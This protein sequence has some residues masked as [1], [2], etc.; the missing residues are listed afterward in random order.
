MSLE[1]CVRLTEMEAGALRAKAAVTRAKAN[2]GAPAGDST[3][4]MGQNKP[5]YQDGGHG[6]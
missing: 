1:G 6:C 3:A 5:S 4:S 2:S